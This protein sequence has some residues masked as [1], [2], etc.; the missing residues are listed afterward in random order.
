MILSSM[1][2]ITSDVTLPVFEEETK[3][4]LQALMSHLSDSPALY[5]DTIMIDQ[6][7]MPLKIFL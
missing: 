1:I 3:I 2:T 4:G 7:K 5:G 6:Q